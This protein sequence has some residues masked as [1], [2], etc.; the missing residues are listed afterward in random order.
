[1]SL[2]SFMAGGWS[3]PWKMLSC[4]WYALSCINNVTSVRYE[5]LAAVTMKFIVFRM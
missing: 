1:M 2:R 3:D 5:V 4:S